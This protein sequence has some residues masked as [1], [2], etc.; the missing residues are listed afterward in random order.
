M[1]RHPAHDAVSQTVRSWYVAAT[2]EIGISV[3]RDAHGILVWSDRVP[4]KRAVL[5]VDAASSV[6]DALFEASELFETCEFD[7]WVDDRARAQRLTAA[8]R[9]AGFEAVQDTVVLALVGSA[10]AG[11]GPEALR[12]EDV[13]DEDG[14]RTWARVKLRGFSDTDDPPSPDQLQQDMSVRRAEWPVCRYQLA[15]LDAEPVAI[16]GHY[17]GEDQMVFLLATR[18]PFRRLGIAQNLLARWS[19]QAATERARSLL[20]N[21]D[22]GGA[23]AT[24]YRRIGFT[25]EVHWHRRFRPTMRMPAESSSMARPASR[26]RE[27]P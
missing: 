5:T 14:L 19:E 20:I 6:P 27:A 16:L 3:A 13:V 17:T 9:D 24:L 4:L 1:D 25:D 21:C 23:P 7:V 12:V 2:P 22:D 26:A 10:R 8:L 18:A 15:Y 11:T